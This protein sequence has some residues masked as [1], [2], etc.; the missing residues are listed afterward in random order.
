[1][2]Q[3]A[4]VMRKTKRKRRKQSKKI[5]V[6]LWKKVMKLKLVQIQ[7]RLVGTKVVTAAVVMSIAPEALMPVLPVYFT[8]TRWN[9]KVPQQ[10]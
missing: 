1:M 9:I 10:M 4:L 8:M 3:Q 6:K 7:K 5:L 2:V